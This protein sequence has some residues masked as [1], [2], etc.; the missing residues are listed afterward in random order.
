[1]CRTKVA[2]KQA[3]VVEVTLGRPLISNV[4][5][6]FIPTS[7][8][9]VISNIAGVFEEHFMDMV[10]LSTGWQGKTFIVQGFGNVGFH[11]CRYLTR[12]GAVFVGVAEREG[13]LYNSEG[14]PA[15][16]FRVDVADA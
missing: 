16:P 9:M 12:A 13:A 8:L 7:I 14:L 11:S 10:G 6:V 5:T 2:K 3:I 1:M 15:M 4:L